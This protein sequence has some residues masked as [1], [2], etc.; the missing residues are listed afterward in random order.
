MTVSGVYY[1]I[2]LDNNILKY[3]NV[4]K[5]IIRIKSKYLKS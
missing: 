2:I 4:I 5:K 1:E 3:I